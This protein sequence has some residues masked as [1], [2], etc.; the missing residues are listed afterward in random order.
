MFKVTCGWW[1]L[2]LTVQLQNIS[3]GQ[4]W[5]KESLPYF[6]LVNKQTLSWIPL[7]CQPLEH[8]KSITVKIS[9]VTT[10]EF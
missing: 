8:A 3:T 7:A 6:I 10:S 5:S 1:L 2:H 9:Q 4:C